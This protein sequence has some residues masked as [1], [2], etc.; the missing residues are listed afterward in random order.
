VVSDGSLSLEEGDERDVSAECLEETGADIG[1]VALPISDI[2]G[3]GVISSSDNGGAGVISSSGIGG[4]GRKSVSDDESIERSP[5][6][7]S[8]NDDDIDE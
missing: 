1:D 6:S 5:M 2:D 4:G 3:A 8:A 7:E